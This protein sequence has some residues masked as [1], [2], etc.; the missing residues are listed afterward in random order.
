MKRAA[1]ITLNP[2]V[3]DFIAPELELSGYMVKVCTNAADS[4][5]KFDFVIVDVD[6]VTAGITDIPVPIVALSQRYNTNIDNIGNMLSWPCR[7][8]DISML[9]AS[10]N[11]ASV[12]DGQ[13]KRKDT[14]T[15]SIIDG[16]TV[17]INNH[18]AKLSHHEMTL[19][20]ELCKANGEVVSRE[21]IMELLGAD[22][23]NI[24]DVYICHLR[25][26]LD[27]QLGRTLIITER[28][29][30]YRTILKLSK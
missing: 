26:K 1:I 29:K 15:V 21:R 20:Q 3:K 10:L 30:G 13:N 23:G 27:G 16:N 5:E 28:G 8:A 18:Y 24:S 22:D 2:A 17:V 6:T 11:N 12:A 4:F 7:L 9:C 19:L 25:R 14:D